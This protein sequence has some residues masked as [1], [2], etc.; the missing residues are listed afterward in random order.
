MPVQDD[1]KVHQRLKQI[2]RKIVDQIV[3]YLYI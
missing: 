2:I 1:S 3:N